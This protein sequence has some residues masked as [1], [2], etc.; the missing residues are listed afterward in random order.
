MM[1]IDTCSKCDKPVDTDIDIDSYDTDVCICEHC[2][3]SI[4]ADEAEEETGYWKRID[5]DDWK[6]IEY[7]TRY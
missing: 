7:N 6:W 2:R 5:V 4:E 1:S 3:Q